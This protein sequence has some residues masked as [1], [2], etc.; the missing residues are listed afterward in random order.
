MGFSGWRAIVLIAVLFGL[1]I[2]VTKF[3]LPGWIV[4]IGLIAAGTVL[5]NAEKKAVSN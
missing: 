4:P 2:L 5:K 1:V 3:D